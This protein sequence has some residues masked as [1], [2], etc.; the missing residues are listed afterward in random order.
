[1]KSKF[2]KTEIGVI[3]EEWEVVRIKDFCLKITSGGTPS[4]RKKEYWERGTIPWLKTQELKDT[5]IFESEEKITFEGLKNSSA[6]LFPVNTILIA[7]YGATVGKLGLLK[8][9]ATTNQAICAMVVNEKITNYLFLFYSL[10]NNRTKLIN[11]ASG[12][13]QQNINQDII[14]EFKIPLPPLPEQR[15]IA[16]ILSDLD[17]KIELNQQMNKTLEAIGQA[18]FKHWFVDFE[19]PNEKGKPYKSSGGEMVYNEEL[20]KEI[21]K[22]WRVEKIGKKLKVELGGTPDRTN[23]NYWNGDIAWINSGKVNEFRIIEPSEYI[24]KEGLENSATKLLPKRTVVLAITGATLGQ[25]SILEIDS[26]ANQSVIGILENQELPSEYIYFWIRHKI[27]DIIGWRTGGAQQHI[28]KGNV[29]NTF[30]LLPEKETMSRYYN[31]VHQIFEQISVNCFQ[32]QTLSSLR[33][34]LLPK[35]M[36]GKIRVPEEVGK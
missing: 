18:I 5:K 27:N 36:S 14:K 29:E 7:M 13:A 28:N 8:I 20:G 32:S 10:L 4:R 6:K 24:T 21:P 3:P 15:A 25:V 31:I 17:S 9:E 34:S 35:L 26:C 22:G 30:I 12:A 11:L 16:K 19:F 23:L 33:D 2:K 1:M